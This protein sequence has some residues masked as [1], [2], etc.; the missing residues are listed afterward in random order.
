VGLLVN[1]T[2]ELHFGTESPP[3]AQIARIVTG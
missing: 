2:H 3:G 1:P